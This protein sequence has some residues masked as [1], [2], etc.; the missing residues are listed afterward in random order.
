MHVRRQTHPVLRCWRPA[1]TS[2]PWRADAA[3]CTADWPRSSPRRSCKSRHLA[4]GATTA[5]T[6][7][8]RSSRSPSWPVHSERSCSDTSGP[9]RP[10][11]ASCSYPAVDGAQHVRDRPG[12]L[13]TPRGKR[14]RE[15]ICTHRRRLT[16]AWSVQWPP[17][18]RRPEVRANLVFN[19]TSRSTCSGRRGGR[20][21]ANRGAPV[22]TGEVITIK[23]DG[24]PAAISTAAH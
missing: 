15:E 4:S 6:D 7:S 16:E 23:L 21:K 3:R 10:A 13:P 14:T 24:P 5:D 11:S 9:G 17:L 19:R 2:L 1:C 18:P 12:S 20:C 22:M 8:C